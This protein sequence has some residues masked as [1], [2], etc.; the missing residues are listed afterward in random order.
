MRLADIAQAPGSERND[1]DHAGALERVQIGRAG[2][3]DQRSRRA[4]AASGHDHHDRGEDQRENHQGR[5]HRV[6]PTHRQKATDHGIQNGR[7]RAQPDCGAIRHREH[8]FE[9]ACAGNDARCGI[10]RK[11][12]QNHQRRKHPQQPAAVLETM[13]EVIGQRQRV[14][15]VL[16][17]HPKRRRHVAPIGPRARHQPNRNPRLRQAAGIH[18]SGQAQQQPAA[19]VRRARRH[20]GDIAAQPPT[21]KNVIA[22]VLGVTPGG[23]T[24]AHHQQDVHGKGDV[25]RGNRGHVEYAFG[26]GRASLAG[27]QHRLR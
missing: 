17:V 5:L 22:Q 18:G 12:H 2:R 24:D 14:V 19:H 11:E 26:A 6:G 15:A 3:F 27:R 8:A 13:G 4:W 25:Q 21:A 9:Q 16:G 10:D 7:R 1:A 23:K 20:R